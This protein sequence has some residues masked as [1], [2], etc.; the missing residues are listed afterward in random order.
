M[1]SQ[2][3]VDITEDFHKGIRGKVKEEMQSAVEVMD[4]L[5]RKVGNLADEM[6]I[7]GGAV[8]D[9][10]DGKL[11]RDVD[12]VISVNHS[13]Y[14]AEEADFTSNEVVRVLEL[15]GFIRLVSSYYYQG[16]KDVAYMTK[17]IEDKEYQLIIT[18]EKL[19]DRIHQFPCS[20]SQVA[21]TFY[22]GI[23]NRVF[24]YATGLWFIGEDLQT[25]FFG[26]P[27]SWTHTIEHYRGKMQIK[28]PT[29]SVCDMGDN[30]RYLQVNKE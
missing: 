22:T 24:V 11:C 15:D 30:P 21:L 9:W 2:D 13:H 26:G 20:K 7:A 3:M 17:V 25:L 1:I 14:T 23:E 19:L 4:N 18:L 12:I 29:Y 8:N 16:E 6:C 28:Y 27:R 5:I 10:M